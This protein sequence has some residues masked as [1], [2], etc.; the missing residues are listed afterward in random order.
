VLVTRPDPAGSELCKAIQE[1]GDLAIFMPTIDFAPPA[2]QGALMRAIEAIGEQDVLIFISPRAVY[3][4][5]PAIRRAWPQLPPAVTIAAVGQGTAAAL[6]KAGLI[7]TVVPEDE[8]G[9]EGLLKLPVFQSLKGKKIAV[10]RGEGG[11]DW[12]EE[13][14]QKRGATVLPVIVYQRILPTFDISAYLPLFRDEKIDVIVC[15]SFQGV[16]H[17]SIM[18]GKES[19]SSLVQIPL[20]VVSERI[21]SLA[22][23]LGFQRIWVAANASHQAILE[24]LAQIRTELC[25]HQK[26]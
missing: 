22:S 18:V 10:I 6:K 26:K 3:E 14:L 5:I 7:S 21:K 24:I 25:Q 13:T 12:L 2:D 1:A 9:S 15:T 8:W 17:L 23:E 4:S 11:R 16:Q 20:I 19:Q